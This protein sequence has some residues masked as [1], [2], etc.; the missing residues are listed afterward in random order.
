MRSD[1]AKRLRAEHRALLEEELM[2]RQRVIRQ[3]ISLIGAQEARRGKTV[4][5]ILGSVVLVAISLFSTKRLFRSS[6]RTRIPTTTRS[7][8]LPVL[9]A[10]LSGA[11][12]YYWTHKSKR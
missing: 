2:L 8:L 7:G 1:K 5:G 3:R 6:G 11:V 9:M 10:F 4:A 12:K